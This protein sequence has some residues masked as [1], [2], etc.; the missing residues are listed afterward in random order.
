MIVFAHG[1]TACINPT[2][3]R[4]LDGENC[5]TG[6]LVGDTL[7]DC[8]DCPLL[9]CLIKTREYTI[10]PNYQPLN[11]TLGKKGGHL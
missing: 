1:W 10:F 9:V 5:K 7:I 8:D 2:C 6:C 3:K 11:C 4:Y